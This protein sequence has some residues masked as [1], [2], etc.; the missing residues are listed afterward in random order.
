MTGFN[1]AIKKLNKEQLEAVQSIEGPVMVLAGPGTGKTQILALRIAEIL[2][3]TH[4]GPRNILALTFSDTGVTA[5]RQR[6]VEFIGPTAHQVEI[7]TFHSFS[8]DI[9]ATYGFAFEEF[10][11]TNSIDTLEQYRIIEQI[12]LSSNELKIF[13]KIRGENYYVKPVVNTINDAKREAVS[14]DQIKDF[15]KNMENNSNKKV[16]IEKFERRQK[17]LLDLA[18]VFSEYNKYLQSHHLYDYGDMLLRAIELIKTNIEVKQFIQERFQYLLVDEYQDTNNAQNILIELI[19]DFFD[20]PNLFVVGDDK[21]AIYRFQGASVE[22]MAYFVHK[23]PELKIINL[24]TNYRSNNKILQTADKSIS[25]NALQVSKII[26]SKSAKLVAINQSNETPELFILNNYDEELLKIYKIITEQK[27]DL[28]KVAILCRTNQEAKNIA[29]TLNK[30]GVATQ[31]NSQ[32]NILNERPIQ[33]LMQIFNAVINPHDNVSMLSALRIISASDTLEVI[34]IADASRKNNTKIID[35]ALLNPKLKETALQ[36][37]DYHQQSSVLNLVDLVEK[38]IY[39][40][41]LMALLHPKAPTLQQLEVVTA[42][43]TKLK[44]FAFRNPNLYLKD[45]VSYVSSYK[46]YDIEFEVQLSTHRSNGVFVNTVHQAK[47]MEFEA[48][49]I[50]SVNSKNWATKKRASSVELPSELVIKQTSPSDDLEDLRRTFYVALTR[51]K[52]KLLLTCSKTDSNNKEILPSQLV[53]EII[54]TLKV[55]EVQHSEE[56][57]KNFLTLTTKQLPSDFLSQE[58]KDYISE[59]LTDFPFSFT[60]YWDYLNCPRTFLL[61]HIFN[62]PQPFSPTLAYGSAVHKALEQFSRLS[63]THH[64]TKEDLL[65]FFIEALLIEMPFADQ[66]YIDSGKHLL[67]KYHQEVLIELPPAIEVEYNFKKHIVTLGQFWLSGKVDA[68]ELIDSKARTVKLIDYKTGSSSRSKN[69]ILGLTQSSDGKYYA[70][71]KFYALLA[72]RDK[73]FPYKVSQYEIRFVDDKHEFK[74]VSFE[75]SKEEIDRFAAEL[76]QTLTEIVTAT[77]FPQ[78]DE[79]SSIANLFPILN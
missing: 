76:E 50:P 12:I 37:L 25:N 39:E 58:I 40:G 24:I 73:N 32:L 11:L 30:L 66:K 43:I 29:L 9:I 14:P 54:N 28:N 10:R 22:N 5:M 34:K 19:A 6:L 57:I 41:E 59:K 45:F 75:I 53:E 23:Y 67:A 26:D 20:K 18:L 1:E 61:Q 7:A 31:Q 48:V 38:I 27:V 51:A 13:S 47:G 8:N 21:Q 64:P 77:E 72:A 60:S 17:V 69:D 46:N 4:V 33:A 49:I 52:N 3:K 42:F 71:L 74:R 16:D 68:I 2:N 56:E 55:T 65:K 70:Q 78:K 35:T 36:I 79:N 62:F 63:K 15:A 44:E